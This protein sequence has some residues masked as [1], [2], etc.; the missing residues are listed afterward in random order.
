LE[1]SVGKKVARDITPAQEE[2]MRKLNIE[3]GERVSQIFFGDSP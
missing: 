1:E 3:Q 2:K